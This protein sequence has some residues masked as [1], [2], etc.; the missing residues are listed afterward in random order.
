M[1]QTYIG[2]ICFAFLLWCGLS[3]VSSN[4]LPEM[5]HIDIGRICLTFLHCVFSNVPLNRLPDKMHSHTGCI[6]LTFHQC[7]F[8]NVFSKRLPKRMHSHIGCICK[9]FLRCVFSNASSNGLSEGQVG[10]LLSQHCVGF[11]HREFKL[12]NLTFSNKHNNVEKK[13]LKMV[14]MISLSLKYHYPWFIRYTTRTKH[15]LL[16]FVKNFL[17]SVFYF[18]DI[19]H[20][21]FKVRF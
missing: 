6:C 9:T 17:T 3:N 13:I 7:V 18:F 21:N 2:S 14:L 4:Q 10:R 1:R 12:N 15:I 11:S 16:S 20:A 19:S 8:S 5:R